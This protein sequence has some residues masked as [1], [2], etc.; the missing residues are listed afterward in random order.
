MIHLSIISKDEVKFAAEF[1]HYLIDNIEIEIGGNYY[2][3]NREYNEY[4]EL[5]DEI[6]KNYLLR[7][8][9]DV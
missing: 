5:Y 4:L 6:T 8:Y 1:G 7:T 9:S 3:N 2:S